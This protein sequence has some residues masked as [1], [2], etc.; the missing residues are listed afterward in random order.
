MFFNHDSE[1][2]HTNGGPTSGDVSWP[3]VLELGNND[4]NNNH[5]AEHDNGSNDEHRLAANLVNDQ[6]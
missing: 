2:S 4:A 5:A 1:M 6:L 3:V